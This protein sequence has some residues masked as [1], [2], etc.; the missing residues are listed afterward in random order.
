MGGI[1]VNKKGIDELSDVIIG[2]GGIGFNKQ[3]ETTEG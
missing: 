1:T 2:L 3:R